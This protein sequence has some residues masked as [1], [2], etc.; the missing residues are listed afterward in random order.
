MQMSGGEQSADPPSLPEECGPYIAIGGKS[1][2]AFGAVY[3]V[4]SVLVFGSLWWLAL[5]LC[6]KVC[7]IT[8]WDEDR[9]VHDR[10]G[11]AWSWA[12][13]A[14]GGCSPAVVT[15]R[16]HLP[17]T[18]QAAL[19]V[20]NHA[21]WFD[22]PLVAQIIPNTFKFVAADELRN[23]P[24]VGQ[25]LVDGKHVLIDRST[26]RGQLRSFKESVEYLKRGISIFAFPEGTRSRTGR[27]MDFKGGVFSMATKAG[28]PIVP[29]SI[30]GAY[31]TYPPNAVLPILPNGDNIQIHIHP[32]VNSLG[33]TEEELEALT[34]GAIAS[35]L[36]PESLPLPTAAA[37]FRPEEQASP[38][39]PLVAA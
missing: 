23:L 10:I 21:S 25:Q 29:I 14:V 22:I 34:R 26:R 3:G 32:M 2:N 28:V 13:M 6:E 8:G 16:E 19:Y 30:V 27:L 7:E 20:S 5:T 4:Q 17:P 24:L 11:K 15:G 33:R 38:K 1:L 18:D 37:E 35:A 9:R 36:P 31:E 12:N 39:E